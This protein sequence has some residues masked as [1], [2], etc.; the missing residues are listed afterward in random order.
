MLKVLLKVNCHRY[1]HKC[2]KSKNVGKIKKTVHKTS[3]T[4][5][6]YISVYQ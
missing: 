6:A 4:L 1:V 2:I 5:Y 3:T